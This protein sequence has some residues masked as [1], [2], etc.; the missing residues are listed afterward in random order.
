MK[1][2]VAKLVVKCMEQALELSKQIPDD[3]EDYISLYINLGSF[4]SR[5]EV[6]VADLCK[7]FAEVRT[8]QVID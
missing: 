3:R 6:S 4:L 1:A 7:L 5:K 2:E 8:E